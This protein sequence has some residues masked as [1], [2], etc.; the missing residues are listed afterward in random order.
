MDATATLGRPPLGLPVETARLVLHAAIRTGAL[1][2]LDAFLHPIDP[3]Q[4]LLARSDTLAF[5]APPVLPDE[6]LRPCIETLASNWGIAVEVWSVTCSQ[7][8]RKLRTW[9][10]EWST[11]LPSLHAACANWDSTLQVLPWGW[12][13]TTTAFALIEDTTASGGSTLTG[14]LTALGHDPLQTIYTVET[15]GDAFFWWRQHRQCIETMRHSKA[16]AWHVPF[17]EICTA[18]TRGEESFR[19]L[20]ELKIQFMEAFACYQAEYRRWHEATFGDE[21]VTTLRAT[22]ER[23]DF[24]AVKLLARLPLPIPDTTASCLDAL[25]QARAHYCP[26]SYAQFDMEGL[27]AHCRLPLD[28]PSPM[29]SADIIRF[30]AAQ[31]LEEY[32][33][34]LTQHRWSHATRER[35]SRAPDYLRTHAESLFAWQIERGSGELLEILDESLLTWLCR[36]QPRKGARQLAQLHQQ[37]RGKDLTISEARSITI[38]WLNPENELNDA[39]ILSFE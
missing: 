29:P 2:G 34:L 30:Q 32:A 5:I 26:G 36:D 7:V 27:C 10:N 35:L 21:I 39:D 15:A 38:E 24:R 12:R 23:P 8:E 1:Q 13:E 14:L 6:S 18:L 28:A 19:Q 9:H 33:S 3:E 22:F 37:L 4:T 25:A 20:T 11:R 31:S 17:H 16:G